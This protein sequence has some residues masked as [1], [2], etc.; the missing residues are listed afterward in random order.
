M[1]KACD[2]FTLVKE[3]YEEKEIVDRLDKKFKDTKANFY[4]AMEERHGDKKKIVCE[5]NVASFEVTR[6]TKTITTYD[7]V[8]AKEIL[9]KEAYK[10]VII[11]QYEVINMEGLMDYL[12]SLGADKKSLKD[13]FV[14]SA[15]IDKDRLE[16]CVA[17]GEISNE[18]KEAIEVKTEGS[19][20]YTV[21]KLK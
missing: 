4:S 17:L 9:S 13:Y 21:K 19:I 1:T 16:N 3:F 2:D 11:P 8:I 20:Y 5:S 14:C 12:K 6:I 10:K 18:E 15:S 7:T